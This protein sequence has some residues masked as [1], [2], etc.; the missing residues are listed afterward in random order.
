MIIGLILVLIFAVTY[1]EYYLKL[2]VLSQY[3][4][5]KIVFYNKRNPLVKCV[6]EKIYWQDLINPRVILNVTYQSGHKSLLETTAHGLLD[7]WEI[8]KET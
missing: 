5:D 3:M 8:Y 2:K 6:I 7:L 1:L 4:D